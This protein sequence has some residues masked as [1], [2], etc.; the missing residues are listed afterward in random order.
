MVL[1]H[2]RDGIGR[3]ATLIRDRAC[4]FYKHDRI[5]L[6]EAA[7]AVS[8]RLLGGHEGSQR[9]PRSVGTDRAERRRA[10]QG[11][12]TQR[13]LPQAEESSPGITRFYESLDE[14][15][16]T[17]LDLLWAFEGQG[18]SCKSTRKPRRR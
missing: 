7:N 6:D 9:L 10:V 4:N 17:F 18:R 11:R 16:A 14:K 13:Q 12:I 1:R 8:S 5:G 15:P 2:T 3:H